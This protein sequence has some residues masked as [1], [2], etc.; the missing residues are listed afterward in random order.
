MKRPR[1]VRNAWYATR[2]ALGSQRWTFPLLRLAPGPYASVLVNR[3]T[4]VCID[5]FPRSGNTYAAFALLH[6]NPEVRL[7]H[8]THV[9]MQILRAVNLGVPCVVLARPPLDTLTS[10][11]IFA[12]DELSDTIAFKTYIDFH[13]RIFP[14]AGAVV[15]CTFDELVVDPSVLVRRLNR[16]YRTSFAGEEP[17]SD[18]MKRKLLARIERDH[19]AGRKKR[20]GWT[21]PNP[22]KEELKPGVRRRLSRH[23][24]LEVAD[25]AYRRIVG[26]TEAPRSPMPRRDPASP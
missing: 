19:R 25:S 11:C 10:L 8:H 1:A 18:E 3:G 24:L 26:L 14:V 5:G 16:R 6:A 13:R 9:P 20:L 12:D 7:A 17:A 2:Y 21:I 22:E 4:E 15:V 23:P